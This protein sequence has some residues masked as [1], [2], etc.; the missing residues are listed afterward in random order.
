MHLRE[1]VENCC[2]KL[3]DVEFQ[4]ALNNLNLEIEYRANRIPSVQEMRNILINNVLRFRKNK[5]L[6]EGQNA[7]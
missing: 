1:Q 4:F 6:M 2:G 7:N 3:T 5:N